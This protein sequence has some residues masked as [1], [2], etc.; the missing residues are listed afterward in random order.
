MAAQAQITN[1]VDKSPALISADGAVTQAQSQYNEARD[2]AL[3]TLRDQPSYQQAAARRRDASQAVNAARGGAN[4]AT[5]PAGA[6]A[7]PTVVAAAE[8]KLNA[9]DDVTKM[10]EQAVSKDPASIS[11]KA[12]LDQA[13]ADRDALKAQLTAQ[14]Q[15]ST[16]GG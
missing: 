9:G 1:A 16:R 5:Q 13:T 11:A 10:E 4:P 2:R 12:R 7:S 3:S 14:L 15:Q 8:S 6:P